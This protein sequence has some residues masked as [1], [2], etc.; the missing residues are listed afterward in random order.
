ML[1][2]GV[3][4]VPVW[5]YEWVFNGSHI[6]VWPFLHGVSLM[7]CIFNNSMNLWYEFEKLHTRWFQRDAMSRFNAEVGW[8]LCNIPCTPGRREEVLPPRQNGPSAS[9]WSVLLLS[10]RPGEPAAK[11]EKDGKGWELP[12]PCNSPKRRLVGGPYWTER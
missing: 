1:S 7:S 4:T 9:H 3:I 5:G 12:P 10:L 11:T 6:D 8:T 2:Q